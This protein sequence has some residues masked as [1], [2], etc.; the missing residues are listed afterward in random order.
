MKFG[1]SIVALFLALSS[2]YA[3]AEE[4]DLKV[5]NAKAEYLQLNLDSAILLIKNNTMRVFLFVQKEVKKS[6]NNKDTVS[7]R[8]NIVDSKGFSMSSGKAADYFFQGEKA[9]ADGILLRKIIYS[10]AVG[11][12]LFG[13]D[14]NEKTALTQLE[15]CGNKTP[16]FYRD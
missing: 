6:A 7:F 16:I 13:N 3:V 9:K 10:A 12:D 14:A 1:L 11:K 4:C 2:N 15:I 8:Y 5:N